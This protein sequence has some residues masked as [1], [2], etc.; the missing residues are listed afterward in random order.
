MAAEA[1][2][3][4]TGRGP[5]KII[6]EGGSQ[7]WALDPRR[8]R[9]CE[10]IVCCQNRRGGDWAGATEAH[11]AAF[12]VGKILDVVDAWDGDSGRYLIRISAFAR[13]DVP[14]A[15]EGSRNPVRYKTLEELGIDVTRLAFEPLPSS[16]QE[17]SILS[18]ER[19]P[20]RLA[21][22]GLTITEAKDA[23]AA[24]YGVPVSAVEIVI[25]G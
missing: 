20:A 1:L 3:V 16:G 17:R 25:R 10:Y 4:F 6:S 7:A 19:N 14:N 22:R 13:I 15:W 18:A 23:L 11:G 21:G 2:L 5:D 9:A 8:A 12:L 24:Y